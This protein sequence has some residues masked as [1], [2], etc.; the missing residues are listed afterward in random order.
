M[1]ISNFL[2]WRVNIIRKAHLLGFG[3]VL[4]KLLVGGLAQRKVPPQVRS[5]EG[6][7]LGNSGVGGLGE[8]SKSGGRA[9]RRC[10]AILNTGHHQ[11]LLGDWARYDSG[12]TGSRD[13]THRHGSALAG[14][15]GIE[16]T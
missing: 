7:G 2:L 5:E 3:Q 4:G 15:L 11:Q 13:E 16:I 8:V 12:T 6:I 10:V 9:T 14:Y 1:F